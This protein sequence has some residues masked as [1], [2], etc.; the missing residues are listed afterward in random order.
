VNSLGRGWRSCAVALQQYHRDVRRLRQRARRGEDAAA[1]R[2]ELQQLM[3]DLEV[4]VMARAGPAGRSRMTE[5][6]RNLLYPTLLGVHQA[7]ERVPAGDRPAAWK[8]H[9]DCALTS[10]R[11]AVPRLRDWQGA[12]LAVAL[13]G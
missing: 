4:D 3:F 5:V 6:E 9:L 1:L 7:L 2:A 13:E 11:Q 8:P 12:T 10:L